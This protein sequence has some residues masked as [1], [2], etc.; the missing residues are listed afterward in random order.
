MTARIA[1]HGHGTRVSE[2]AVRAVKEPEF[3]ETWRPYSHG[4]VLDCLGK[5]VQDHGL[6]VTDRDYSLA[7]DGDNLFGTWGLDGGTDKIGWQIGFR[8]SIRKTF[9]LGITAGTKVFVCSNMAFSGEFLEFRRH[10]AHLDEAEIHEVAHR[11]V[12]QLISK[13]QY[14]VDWLDE[15]NQFPLESE[16]F[17]VLTYD[18][19]D[20]GVFSPGKFPQ[21]L[22]CHDEE[23]KVAQ[24]EAPTLYTW[25]GAATRLMRETSLWQIA[26]QT[27][28]LHGVADDYMV[29]LKAA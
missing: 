8:N 5:A 10:T 23:L 14:Q 13:I 18:A 24:T 26:R 28:T 27:D 16:A 20:R 17:K 6:V 29:A 9:A 4:K 15:L 22:A 2:A 3:T 25:H 7:A 1:E 19:M 12:G 21:F 11:A